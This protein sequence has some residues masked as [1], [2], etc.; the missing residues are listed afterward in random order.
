MSRHCDVLVRMASP[1]SGESG[2]P[3]IPSVQSSTIFPPMTRR[4]D[5][6]RSAIGGSG[7]GDADAPARLV[8]PGGV[9]DARAAAAAIC[10]DIR[11]GE[12]LDTSFDRR[13]GD[14]YHLD[15]RD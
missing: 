5:D 12:L 7:G 15:A 11:G 6:S 3:I 13:V 8:M 1:Q 2:T 14:E 9:T 10:T 4:W